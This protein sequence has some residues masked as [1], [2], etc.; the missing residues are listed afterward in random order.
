MIIC[1]KL[2]IILLI[3]YSLFFLVRAI[4]CIN[5]V[6]KEKSK[7]ENKDSVKCNKN[8]IIAIPCL[9]EQKC[10][11]DTIKYFTEIAKD[12]P[13]IIVTT[14]KEVKENIK[15]DILTQYII[16]NKILPKYKNVY[17]ID[18]PFTEGYMADQLNYMIEEIK[19]KID[20]SNASI[21]IFRQHKNGEPAI[22]RPCE[23]CER[24]IRS[25][26]IKKVFYT[27]ENGFAEE[28]WQ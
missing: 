16:K 5:K 19:N 8:I 4:I 1:I 25:L 11:E 27:I 7:R 2:V 6:K 22:A 14:Q 10:I 13:I 12:I 26:G 15:N 24:V 23:G 28:R 20:L 17:L 21:Y 3:I 9:R 18:Y